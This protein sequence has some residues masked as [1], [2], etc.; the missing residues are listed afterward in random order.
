MFK[1]NRFAI[2]SVLGGLLAVAV[3]APASAAQYFYD[4][5][6][7]VEDAPIIVSLVDGN[8]NT[9][10]RDPGGDF[11]L[12]FDTSSVK[13]VYDDTAGTFSLNGQVTGSIE[14]NGP[15]NG[16]I[17]NYHFVVG[18]GDEGDPNNFVFDINAT[19]NNELAAYA[20]AN[21]SAFGFGMEADAGSIE[22]LNPPARVN[23]VS[24]TGT[25]SSISAKNGPD[26]FALAVSADPNDANRLIGAG[27]LEIGDFL[28]NPAL[29]SFLGQGNNARWEFGEK[30]SA[31]NW[32]LSLVRTGSTEV[33]EPFT[34]G[35][36]GLGCLGGSL[37][38]KR[39]QA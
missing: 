24:Y 37:I 11:N 28:N 2:P 20:G 25:T 39:K 15:V 3:A 38:R 18:G 16:G 36:L 12:Y 23:A 19:L 30:N 22:L 34:A 5:R 21:G 13:A 26:G 14:Y 9:S 1:T 31:L 29:V 35:L 7:N 33:P 27:W 4:V 8:G 17:S 32:N 6:G 10:T